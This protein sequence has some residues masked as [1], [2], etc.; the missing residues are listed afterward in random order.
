MLDVRKPIG[1]LF[2]VIGLILTVYGIVQPQ[3]TQVAIVAT[4]EI[5]TLNID[6]PCGASMLAFGVLMLTLAAIDGRKE[7]KDA[8]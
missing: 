2:V 8:H 1:Y 5:V 3:Y 6:L 4:K 7:K